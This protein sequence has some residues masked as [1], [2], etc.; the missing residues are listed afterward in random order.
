MNYLRQ[1][2]TGDNKDAAFAF[3]AAPNIDSCALST[4]PAFITARMRVD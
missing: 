3:V 4:A 1:N 2:P